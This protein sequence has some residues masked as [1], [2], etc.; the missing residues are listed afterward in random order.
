[1]ALLEIVTVPDPVLKQEAEELR[2]FNPEIER[3]VKDMAETMYHAP[4]IGLAANQ[5]GLLKQIAVVD[6]SPPEE[7]KKLI[8]LVNPRI[9]SM[10]G[11]DIAEEGCLSVPDINVEIKRASRIK[12]IAKN[13]R[14]E[15]IELSAEGLLARAIQHELDHLQGTVILDKA[16]ILKRRRY[17]NNLKKS[18]TPAN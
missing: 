14:G 9:I 4:G 1:M 6:V 18:K 5:V 8:V 11:E 17:L 7:E 12:V 13:L 3:V 10:E 15:D 2:D 16:S